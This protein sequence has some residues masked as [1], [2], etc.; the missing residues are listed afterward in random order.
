MFKWEIL[1]TNNFN[2]ISLKKVNL[3]IKNL[4]MKEVN[5]KI[6]N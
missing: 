6:K 2:N 5:Q 1:M 3:K 4:D